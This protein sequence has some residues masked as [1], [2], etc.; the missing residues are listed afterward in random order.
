[1]FRLLDYI[2]TNNK[3]H[4]L[5]WRLFGCSCGILLVCCL[6][7]S[8][9]SDDSNNE[10]DEQ[11][12]VVSDYEEKAVEYSDNEYCATIDYY[13]P[14]TGTRSTY[15]L[16]V[17]VE[18]GEVIQI[19]WPNGGWLDDSHFTPVGFDEDGICSFTTYEGL[20][21]DVKIEGEGNCSYSSNSMDEEQPIE[22]SYTDEDQE[23]QE[24]T[25]EEIDY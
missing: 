24:E 22:D 14:S 6:A 2:N 9:R 10:I 4:M 17:L 25:E 12:T 1:M 5:L 3:N 18:D 16:T 13:N 23:E 8:T 20:E 19:N 15:T 7:C 21:Y 11:Q